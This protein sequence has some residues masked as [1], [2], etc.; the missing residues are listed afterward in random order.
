MKKGRVL[1]FDPYKGFGKIE[2]LSQEA[3][4]FVHVNGLVDQ[5]REGTLVSYQLVTVDGKEQAYDVRKLKQD[6]Q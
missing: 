6:N 4:I 1:F 5:V 3:P 2:P